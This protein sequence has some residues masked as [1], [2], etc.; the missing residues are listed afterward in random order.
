MICCDICEDWYHG[1][2]VGVTQA[3][4]K[5]LEKRAEEWMCPKC[6][7]EFLFTF[8]VCIHKQAWARLRRLF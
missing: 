3:D 1:D 7:S 2:C 8:I 4:G 5:E 6:K